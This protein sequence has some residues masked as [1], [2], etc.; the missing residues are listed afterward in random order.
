MLKIEIHECTPH[1]M[2]RAIRAA[3]N[4]LLG[5]TD[6]TTQA[7]E[8]NSRAVQLH[9]AAEA[10]TDMAAA[11]LSAHNAT[12]VS[13]AWKDPDGYRH[14]T[15]FRQELNEPPLGKPAEEL[16]SA[17][18]AWNAEL[19][20]STKSKNA[21]GT[22][23]KRRGAAVPSVQINPGPHFPADSAPT[24]PVPPA[25]TAPLVTMNDIYALVTG[26]KRTINDVIALAQEVGFADVGAF[27]RE[28]TPEQ[29]AEM[30]R[31]LEG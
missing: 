1:N 8:H 20:A 16:D 18:H 5:D 14:E 12:E 2:L 24:P 26:G 13:T 9:A 7:A 31:K 6:L 19:H 3:C 4:E 21:D 11:A 29:R 30:L 23:K 28:A 17:G 10:E 22:W 15:V 25:P 27:S